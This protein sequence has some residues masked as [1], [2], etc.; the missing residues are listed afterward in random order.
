MSSKNLNKINHINTNYKELLKIYDDKINN[1]T[2]AIK[3]LKILYKENN[4]LSKVKKN[5]SINESITESNITI[6]P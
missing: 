2:E 3:Q 1:T 5:K 4:K 6:L